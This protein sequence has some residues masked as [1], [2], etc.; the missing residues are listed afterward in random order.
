MRGTTT[1]ARGPAMIHRLALGGI[2]TAALG[3]LVPAPAVAQ[4]V[5]E[6][7]H[8]D[9]VGSVRIVT[10]ANGTVRERHDYLPFGEEC[11][12]GPC[13]GNPEAGSGQPRKFASKER[14]A[15]GLDYFGARYYLA[16][17]GRFTTPD[18]SLDANR[19]AVSPQHWNRYSYA[20][21][22][23]RRFNDPDGRE[24]GM[25]IDAWDFQLASGSM[26]L[27]EHEHRVSETTKAGG[28]SA[29]LAAP[30]VALELVALVPELLTF[31]VTKAA[32]PSNQ[33]LVQEL[34]EE[35]SGGPP[36][37]IS[38]LRLLPAGSPTARLGQQALEH[39]VERHW[40]TSSAA[41][42]GKFGLGTTARSLRR[43]ID[44][45]VASGSSRANTMGRPGTIFEYDFGRTIGIDIGGSSTS[46]LR[47]VV[48][49][50][51]DVTTAFP[52]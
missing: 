14:D 21:N 28:M 36:G 27:A 7:F 31:A 22:N 19:A 6:Y 18:P 34:L 35:G 41:G 48:D 12:T 13:A 30:F 42:A 43:M 20:L 26:S 1:E 16:N 33:A 23:T 9:A 5:I 10:D 44:E 45:A 50:T 25:A 40:A 2:V 52:Y 39:I 46:R 38:P 15:T 4:T 47:V 49:P 8:V 51:G 37:R 3:A 29:A 32:D 17:I 11:T 24:V